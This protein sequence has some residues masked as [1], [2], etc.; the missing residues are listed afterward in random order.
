VQSI[1][2]KTTDISFG[3]TLVIKNTSFGHAAFYGE[4]NNEISTDIDARFSKYQ[5]AAITFNY[6][7]PTNV[8]ELDFELH[9][10]GQPNLLEMQNLLLID[11]QRLVCADY[12]V[13]AVVPCLVSLQIKLVKK[14]AIDTFE[15][16]NLQQLKKDIFNYV[17]TI[18]FGEHLY[19]SNIIKLCHNYNIKRVD[20]PIA[21]SGQILAPDG[22]VVYLTSD[23]AL[24]IPYDI[25]RGISPKT[26]NYFI[27]Y[28]RF[29]NG[30]AQPI[31]N[32]GINI[33]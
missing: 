1:I 12:L 13:K 17:N 7:A 21:M 4:R 5:T 2:P 33:S 22:T 15:S 29:E 16:L 27:D 10:L 32:I 25:P 26:T 9:V 23:D 6:E 18:P 3:G 30:A 11:N 31:D 19:A 28:Y 20:L 14:S 8:T 24:P